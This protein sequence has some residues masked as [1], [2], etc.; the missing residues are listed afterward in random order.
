[1]C[2]TNPCDFTEY[3]DLRDDGLGN[4]RVLCA[5]S[6]SP[7]GNEPNDGCHA[8]RAVM[9]R[10]LCSLVWHRHARVISKKRA[11]F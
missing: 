1:M 9:E 2:P 4:K 3:Y 7:D 5:G 6:N 8:G 11:S 10:L